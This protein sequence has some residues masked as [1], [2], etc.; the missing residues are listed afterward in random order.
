MILLNRHIDGTPPDSTYIGRGSAFGNLKVIGKDGS[1][2]EVINWYKTWLAFKLIN[3]DETVEIAF[4]KLN[5]DSKLLCFCAPKPCHGEVIQEYWD[6]VSSHPT[7]EEG[8]K[9]LAQTVNLP[10]PEVTL[11]TYRTWLIK[12]LIARDPTVTT[13]FRNLELND[14]LIPQEFKHLKDI[15]EKVLIPLYNELT[16]TDDYDMCINNLARIHGELC[17]YNPKLD[18]ITHINVYSK[19]ST[20]LG[21]MLTNFSGLGIE[22]PE[23]GKF[24]SIEGF[25]YWLKTG[26]RFDALRSLTGWIAKEVGKKLEVV[27]HPT[28]IQEVKKALLYKVEQNINLWNMLK[29]STLPLTHYY[30]YG[31][32]DNAKIIADDN[33]KWFVEYLELLRLYTKG[34][35]HKLIIAGSRTIEEF[36]VVETAFKESKIVPV[37]IVSGGARGVDKLGEQLAD[38]FSVPIQQFIP[39]WDGLGKRAGMVRNQHM[40]DYATALLALWDGESKGTKQMI[41]Y[42]SKLNKLTYVEVVPS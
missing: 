14:F 36:S 39:D 15:S 41:D 5:K 28:F 29:E 27:D 11:L 31:S 32:I 37:L 10:V 6:I 38:K 33:S 25:W 17:G 22:H 40:G 23:Y 4:R 35:A 8:L 16:Q 7:Y 21:R 20:P 12:Q 24:Q 18:G 42:M 30:Y 9:A 3:R 34:L 1:R 26:M 19:G 2:E 13:L